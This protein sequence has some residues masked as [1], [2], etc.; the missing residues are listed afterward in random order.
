MNLGNG[1]VNTL[2]NNDNNKKAVSSSPPQLAAS[3]IEQLPDELLLH[4]F[5]FLQAFDL[6]EVGLTCYQ[7]KNLAE[8]ETLWKSLYVRYFKVIE[9][10]GE[11]YK[12]SYFRLSEADHD[13]R[14]IDELFKG[15]K[16][17]ELGEWDCKYAC[18]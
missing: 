6:F 18:K 15:F 17:Y 16:A 10:V 12:K 2:V 14:K 9:P 4:T 8:E 5:S 13:W 3:S 1:I 11:T 7:W